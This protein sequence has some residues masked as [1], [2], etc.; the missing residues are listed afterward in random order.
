MHWNMVLDL[1]RTPL[2]PFFYMSPFEELTQNPRSDDSSRLHMIS[3]WFELNGYGLAEHAYTQTIF[4]LIFRK[5]LIDH[6]SLWNVHFRNLALTVFKLLRLRHIPISIYYQPPPPLPF[7]VFFNNY[8]QCIPIS[9]HCALSAV[10]SVV[11]R[12]PDFHL[13]S[14]AMKLYKKINYIEQETEGDV[15]IRQ[16]ITAKDR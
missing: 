7:F 6:L 15:Q 8:N 5:G 11:S 12:V 2:L 4:S 3:D 16:D 14:A 13:Q 9:R 1:D 10:E